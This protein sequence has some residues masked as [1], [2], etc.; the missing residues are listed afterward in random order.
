MAYELQL[1]A[2][3][4]ALQRVAA[5]RFVRHARAAVQ[6]SGRF[7]VAL[8]G[9]STPRAMYALLALDQ[10]MRGAVPWDKVHVFW[11]D[12]RHVPPDHADSNYHM[13]RAQLLSKVPVPEANVQRIRGEQR[14]A[15]LIARQYERTLQACFRLSPGQLPRFDLVLLGLGSDGHTASLFPGT[16]ALHES[17]RLVA[18]N[19]VEKLQAHRIT[20]TVPV[21]NNAA[22]VMF[23]VAGED[24]ATA[25]HAVLEGAP[26]PE[27]LPAQRI[28]PRDGE[29]V[30]LVDRA[31]SRLLTVPRQQLQKVGA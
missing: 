30:W 26:G 18:V 28:R 23:L 15:E 19:W 24:K 2:D 6:V 7:T 25:L 20:L 10:A 4:E 11:G 29:L 3:A 16:S 27:K 8:S 13:A 12:E 14:D 31:A 5:E 1:V 9:G 17:W 22:C 21:F